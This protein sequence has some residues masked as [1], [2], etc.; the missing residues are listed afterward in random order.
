MITSPKTYDLTSTRLV[1]SHCQLKFGAATTGS[2]VLPCLHLTVHDPGMQSQDA[3]GSR[4]RCQLQGEDRRSVSD[5][6]PQEVSF[7]LTVSKQ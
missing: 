6:L 5:M 7:L 3:D 4:Q 1:S 2:G